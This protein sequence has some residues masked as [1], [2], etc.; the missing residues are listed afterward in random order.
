MKTVYLGLFLAAFFGVFANCAKKDDGPKASGDLS[1]VCFNTQMMQGT[2]QFGGPIQPNT[3]C[4]YN[5]QAVGGGF[6]QYNAV[7]G[8]NMGMTN[9][10]SGCQQG[11]QEVVYSPTKGLGCVQ[12]QQLTMSG[13]PARYQLNQ[14]AGVFQLA[15]QTP[16]MP[17]Q[18]WYP[19]NQFGANQQQVLRVCDPSEPC[20]G[21]QNCR[22][23]APGMPAMNG[24]GICYY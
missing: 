14:M 3:T 2:Q 6:T 17:Q 7:G 16:F 5:Y 11:Y 18:Q 20:P 1:A 13:M 9:I 23:P 4:G 24:I 15:P 10:A 21:G 19:Y 8:M 22:A 12:S